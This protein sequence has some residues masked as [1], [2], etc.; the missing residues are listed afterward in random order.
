VL[1]YFV[2][3]IFLKKFKIFDGPQSEFNPIMMT[4]LLPNSGIMT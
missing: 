4:I 2:K 1:A 3:N